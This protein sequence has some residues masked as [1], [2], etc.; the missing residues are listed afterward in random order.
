[1]AL[2][3]ML[4]FGLCA[5]VATFKTPLLDHHAWRQADT[6]AIARN[7]Y[8][9]RLNILYPQVDERGAAPVGYV[10][11][12]FE[13][14]AFAVALTSRVV[15]FHFETGRLLNAFLFLISGTLVWRFVS[16]RDGLEHAVTAVF[17][18]AFAFPLS[19]FIDRAFMNEASLI[20][21]SLASIVAAQSYL[22][23]RRTAQLLI[24]WSATSLVGAIKLP[25]LIVWAPVTALFVEAAGRAVWRRW[26][27]WLMVLL[28]LT[29][30]GLWYFHA[31]NLAKVTGITFGLFDK[32]FDAET[33][34]SRQFIWTIFTRLGKDVLG[35]V[36]LCGV[37]VGGWVA[38][39]QRRWFE[40][41]LKSARS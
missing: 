18:Y 22:R 14:F 16:R 12:G 8:A 36:G 31:H 38:F 17:L 9:E 10:E 24:L 37:I 40:P 20:C 30:A 3:F 34:F 39:R 23:E 11:T 33:V 7:F 4:L 13:A 2:G 32:T 25:Y 35:P 28:N 29:A 41:D 19:L 6:A 26:E 27:L 21:L 1:L 15:G 5:R